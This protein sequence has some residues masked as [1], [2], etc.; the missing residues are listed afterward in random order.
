MSKKRSKVLDMS[1]ILLLFTGS[2]VMGILCFQES[3]ILR[4]NPKLYEQIQSILM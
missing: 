2:K 3:Q 1:T 4:Q